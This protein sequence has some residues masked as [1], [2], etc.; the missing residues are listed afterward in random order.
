MCACMCECVCLHT[1]VFVCV[2]VYAC[3]FVCVCLY[4]ELPISPLTSTTSSDTKYLITS[5]FPSRTE[6]TNMESPDLVTGAVVSVHVYVYM[7]VW[8]RVRVCV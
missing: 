8:V 3:M 1:C 4:T 7:C 6:R 2:C 5:S